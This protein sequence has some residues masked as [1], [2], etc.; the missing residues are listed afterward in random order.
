[1]R[2][3]GSCSL[4]DSHRRILREE[5]CDLGLQLTRVSR[6]FC[7]QEPQRERHPLPAQQPGSLKGNSAVNGALPNGICCMS[8]FVEEVRAGL[9]SLIC[10]AIYSNPA[11]V[12]VPP[13]R[14]IYEKQS[15]AHFV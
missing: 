3:L 7:L 1:M 12:K 14:M 8:M 2:S 11:R 6:S 10:G 9:F 4:F 13:E 5:G 15:E